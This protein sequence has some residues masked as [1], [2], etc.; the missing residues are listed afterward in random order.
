MEGVCK[1]E[2]LSVVT[3]QT[4]II[5]LVSLI[6]LF[7]LENGLKRAHLFCLWAAS[8]TLH[9][10]TFSTNSISDKESFQQIRDRAVY[11]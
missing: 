6:Y 8:K 5:K 11:R 9:F 7:A 1:C 10:I 2:T 4:S 3:Q